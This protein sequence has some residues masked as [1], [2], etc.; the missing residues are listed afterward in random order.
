MGICRLICGFHN[1]YGGLIIFG[2]HDQTRKAGHNKVFVNIERLNTRL[3]ELL[4]QPIEC[5]HRRYRSKAGKSI[6]TTQ[7]EDDTFDIVLVP[8]RAVSSP[9]VR[10]ASDIGKYKSSD[11]FIRQNHEVVRAKSADITELYS[12]RSSYGLQ[13][14]D[15]SSPI[16]SALPQRPSTLRNFIG[17]TR[18]LDQ[19][20]SWFVASENTR[21]FFAIG[22]YELINRGSWPQ[23]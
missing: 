1:R 5:V 2:V 23:V 21:A 13:Q 8:K 7:N 10:F 14:E 20:F 16:P 15:S 11:I 9:V 19:I 6:S 3:R 18:V 4:N 12:P 22:I 17:R